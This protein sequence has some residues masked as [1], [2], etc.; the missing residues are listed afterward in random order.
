MISPTVE[1]VDA[2]SDVQL[3]QLRGIYQEAFPLDLRVPFTELTVP[4]T[5]D[6]TVVALADPAAAGH[7]RSDRHGHQN[8]GRRM[9]FA[10][11]LV[12]VQHAFGQG[13]AQHT[14]HFPRQVQRVTQPRCH[15][16]ADERRGEVGGVTEDEHI[17]VAPA[18]GHLR[19]EG[20]R[21]H[22]HQRRP[23]GREWPE[24]CVRDVR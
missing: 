16:L 8:H 11:L 18:A 10:L 4:G 15:T 1:P 20:V 24:R 21:R 14:G 9:G 22:A 7:R 23:L 3:G 5:L 17:A 13:L 6:R 19:A 2:V 12:G